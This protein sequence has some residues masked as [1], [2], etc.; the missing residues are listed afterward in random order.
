MHIYTYTSIYI[1]I[2]GVY[3]E[4][5]VGCILRGVEGAHTPGADKHAFSFCLLSAA[6]L[7]TPNSRPLVFIFF[8]I[9]FYSSPKRMQQQRLSY[10]PH[11]LL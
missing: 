7:L 5:C 1:Y 3:T 6:L 9:I 2:F 10:P 8:F 11:I 4:V